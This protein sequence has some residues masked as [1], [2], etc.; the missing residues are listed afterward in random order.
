M[1]SHKTLN[2]KEVCPVSGRTLEGGLVFRSPSATPENW[3]LPETGYTTK[4]TLF[5]SHLVGYFLP[6]V[7]TTSDNNMPYVYRP[8]YCSPT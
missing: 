8:L 5:Q 1:K 2:T 7:F 3:V 6:N 4:Q